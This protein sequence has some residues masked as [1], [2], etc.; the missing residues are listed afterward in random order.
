MNRMRCVLLAVAA[1]AA[2]VAPLSAAAQ[3][4]DPFPGVVEELSSISTV[5]PLPG[6]AELAPAAVAADPN[7]AQ[8]TGTLAAVNHSWAQAA[9]AKARALPAAIA[10]CAKMA[11]ELAQGLCVLSVTGQLSGG[12]GGAAP[13]MPLQTMPAPPPP[14]ARP[15]SVWEALIRAPAALFDAAVKLGPS[16]A[17]YA[18]GKATVQSQE[19][20][21]VAQTVERAGLYTAFSTINGQSVGAMRDVA[22]QGFITI[23]QIPQGSTYNVSNSTGV[24]FGSGAIN[25]TTTSNSHNPRTCTGGTAGVATPPEVGG[26]GGSA[27]C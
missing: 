7:Y 17:Q 1:A 14:P 2:L 21:A 13:L 3:S 12:G 10:A 18:L 5:V 9:T 16:W 19:R 11:G 27:T 23:G 15:L 22:T 25:Y 26:P 20:I 4:A 24:G 6:V 8:A